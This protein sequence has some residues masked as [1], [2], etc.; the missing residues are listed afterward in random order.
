MLYA[1]EYSFSWDATPNWL[2]TWIERIGIIQAIERSNQLRALR[3]LQRESPT[4]PFVF[5]S[6]RGSPFTKPGFARMIERA[7]AGAGLKLKAHPHM[8][9]PR[10]RLRPR[11]QMPRH[12]SDPGLARA[13]FDHQHGGLHGA[14][15]EPVQGFLA[16]APQAWDGATAPESRVASSICGHIC[17]TARYLKLR[18]MVALL[19]VIFRGM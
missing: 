19:F 15:A 8:A 18:G 4:S 17:V 1:W 13:S 12:P 14:S 16:V 5:V 9:A 6:E 10:L 11:Q 2:K 7:A 3:R